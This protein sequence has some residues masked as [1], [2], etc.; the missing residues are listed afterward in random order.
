MKA[1][2]CLR[3]IAPPTEG[4]GRATLQVGRPKSCHSTQPGRDT[5]TPYTLAI[6]SI[7]SKGCIRPSSIAWP[8][9]RVN[10]VVRNAWCIAPDAR[11]RGV[12]ADAVDADADTCDCD[13]ADADTCDCDADA[14]A[15]PQIDGG[16]SGGIGGR[17]HYSD[18]FVGGAGAD[19]VA[20]LVADVVELVERLG[21]CRRVKQ[22]CRR[23]CRKRCWSLT[24]KLVGF[25]SE[26]RCAANSTQRRVAHTP[27]KNQKAVAL[28]WRSRRFL[29]CGTR[30]VG[31]HSTDTCTHDYVGSNSSGCCRKGRG[32]TI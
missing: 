25:G 8:T 22:G 29:K 5:V 21:N 14:N 27:G 9:W 6:S 3:S 32:G 12:A 16:G 28:R 10:F 20:M 15:D 31:A 18:H 1:A 30:V 11:L 7:Q 23:N 19:V 2:G 26:R 17:N 24:L 4:R 13:D